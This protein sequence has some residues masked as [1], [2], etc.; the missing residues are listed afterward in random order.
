M[1]GN[2]PDTD[3]DAAIPA[4]PCGVINQCMVALCRGTDIHRVK[5][6]ARCVLGRVICVGRTDCFCRF[7]AYE[8]WLNDRGAR[9]CGQCGLNHQLTNQPCT[10]NSNLVA[11]PGSPLSKGMQG[12]GIQGR[13]SGLLV[14]DLIG[15]G[16]GEVF[17]YHIPLGMVGIVHAANGNPLPACKVG[18]AICD[19]MHCARAAVSHW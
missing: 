2:I 4:Q 19:G 12:K 13:K 6:I 9:T 8:I 3:N 5:L 1:R 16:A 7:M 18:D 11:N 10:Q 15:N 14:A 17:R